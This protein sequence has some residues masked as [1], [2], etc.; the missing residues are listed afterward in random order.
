MSDRDIKPENADARTWA[1]RIGSNVADVVDRRG[2]KQPESPLRA[3]LV[4]NDNIDRLRSSASAC[5]KGHHET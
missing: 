5:L 1:V 3:P 2:P 4:N